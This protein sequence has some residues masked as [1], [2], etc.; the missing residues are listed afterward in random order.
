MDEF[1]KAQI[2]N[3]EIGRRNRFFEHLIPAADAAYRAAIS[4]VPRDATPMFGRITLIG[5]KA[6]LSAAVLI[7]KLL[8]E[9]SV[10]ITRRALEA[11]RFALAMKINP[12]NAFEWTAYQQRHDRWLQRQQGQKPQPFTPHFI[13]VRDDAQYDE[14]GR[15]LGILSDASVHFTPEFYTSLNWQVRRTSE[16]DGEIHL[17]YFQNSVRDVERH[18]MTLGVA[19]TT[20]LMVLDRCYDGRFQQVDEAKRCM[21]EFWRIG[22]DLSEVFKRDHDLEGGRAW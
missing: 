11:A 21:D 22:K 12:E 17:E 16:T 8:P 13:D 20:I 15:L 1:I 19:H 6:L 4:C 3:L 14:I 7:A 9:D 5:H 2:A 18:F 10:G